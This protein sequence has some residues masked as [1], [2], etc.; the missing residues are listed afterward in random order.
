MIKLL[1]C[2]QEGDHLLIHTT[3]D[4]YGNFTSMKYT[5]LFISISFSVHLSAQVKSPL[6]IDAYGVWERGDIFANDPDGN[7]AYDFLRGFR[8]DR[9]WSQIQPI[10]AEIEQIQS[11][12]LNST[13]SSLK[14]VK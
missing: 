13:T 4:Q 14:Y 3:N 6:P 11:S 1:R 8:M 2:E 12:I 5:V 9:E 10:N 7:P